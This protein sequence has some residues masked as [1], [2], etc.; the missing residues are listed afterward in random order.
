MCKA[1]GS[2]T[3]SG[4]PDGVVTATPSGRPD[5]DDVVCIR[6]NG[7]A[8]C[9]VP[10]KVRHSPTGI[11]WGYGGS[12]PADLAFSIL[13]RFTDRETAETLY[14]DFKWDFIACMP[15]EGGVIPAQTIRQ[16]LEEQRGRS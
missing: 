10:H 15:Y 12:G 3:V 14:Q 13:I 4:Q 6:D 2:A 1:S 11:E 16:W 8:R 9:N 5:S 7:T